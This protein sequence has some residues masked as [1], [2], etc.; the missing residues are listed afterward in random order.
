M[1]CLSGSVTAWQRRSRRPFRVAGTA[2]YRNVQ[3]NGT[4]N[5][6]IDAERAPIIRQGFRT[7]AS[8]S[9]Q[10]GAVLRAINANG[11]PHGA[12]QP[13]HTAVVLTDGTQPVYMGWIHSGE[14]KVRG[15]FEAL[16]SEEL[17]TR[18]KTFSTVGVFLSRT[19]GE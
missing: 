9:Y 19:A 8:G 18:C 12:R 13:G 10:R 3:A 11:T 16:V 2:R 5:L 17:F 1:F 15:N 14:N 6:A 4:K 7:A